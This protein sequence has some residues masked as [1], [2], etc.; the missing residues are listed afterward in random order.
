MHGDVEVW[1]EPD[2]A[3]EGLT[4]GAAGAST[5]SALWDHEPCAV[6]EWWSGRVVDQVMEW[7]GSLVVEWWNEEVE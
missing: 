5:Q 4:G 6:V 1:S 7:W 2:R 3:D